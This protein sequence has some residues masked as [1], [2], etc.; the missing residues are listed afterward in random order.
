MK[1]TAAEI[2]DLDTA[3]KEA[4][5]QR[6]EENAAFK[7]L[8]AGNA[9]AKDLLGK[10]KNRLNKFYNP[11]LAK[12]VQIKAHS[13]D[14]AAPG[15][16]PEAPGAFQKKGEESNGVLALLDTLVADLDKET[17]IA[18]TEEKDAQAD[19]ETAMKDAKSKRADSIKTIEDKEAAVADAEAAL[20]TNKD[21]KAS[22]SKELMGVDQYI[23]SL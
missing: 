18:E 21:D 14:E 11:K 3:V 7:E 20:Q 6:E 23:T 1:T 9:A 12:F 8:I 10:A 2:K 16:P 13:Q 5:E 22:A 17:T 4:T 15:P 19:Y